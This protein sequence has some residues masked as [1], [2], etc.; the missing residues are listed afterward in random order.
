MLILLDSNQ[1]VFGFRRTRESCF[2]ITQ[3]LDQMSCVTPYII[4]SEVVNRLRELEGK[5]F[6]SLARHNILEKTRVIS[7]VPEDLIRKYEAQGLKH[8]D[9]EI[10]AFAESSEVDVI[11]SENRHFLK[12]L[13]DKPF[14]V[15][16]AEEF[17]KS[18]S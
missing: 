8:A 10:A 6:A 7:G 13:K 2:R 12:E 4:L 15:V 17:L 1:F 14:K 5:D 16:C 18:I 3:L 11:V 9:A